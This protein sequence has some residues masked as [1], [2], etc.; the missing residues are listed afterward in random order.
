M[1]DAT[2]T[3]M[4]SSKRGEYTTP[5]HIFAPVQKRLTLTFDTAA[6][7]KRHLLP[8]YATQE[9]TFTK[10]FTTA[11]KR[12]DA[13]GLD[14]ESW[15]GRRVWCNPPYG[16]GIEAW[17]RAAAL[18]KPEVAALLL[19]A[20]TETEWFQRWVAPYAEVHFIMGRITFEGHFDKCYYEDS[21]VNDENG[22]PI[23]QL[24]EP[25]HP[26]HKL[27]AAPFPNIL[28]IYQPG[29]W[30]P[31]GRVSGFTWDPRSDEEWDGGLRDA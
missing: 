8:N 25:D 20:R 1:D 9:G 16:R 23:M 19:P 26:D 31:R 10:N 13:T 27:D 3:L 14:P 29:V 7:E 11:S 4:F 6:S 30:V 2:R 28:A 12:S 24:C 5:Q 15:D 22:D 18:N 17:V 21:G